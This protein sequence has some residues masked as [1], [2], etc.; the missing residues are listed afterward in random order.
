VSRAARAFVAAVMVAGPAVAADAQPPRAATPCTACH[1]PKGVATMPDAPHI[2]GQ[3]RAYLVEQLK[4]FRS[5]RRTH[6]VMTFMAKNLSDADIQEIA[7]WYSSFEIEVK[8]R[9]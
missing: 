3:P 6:E 8:P 4:A 9:P 7:D 2:A 5:G 1:G